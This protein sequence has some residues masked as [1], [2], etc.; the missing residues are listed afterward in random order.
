[1][2]KKGAGTNDLIFSSL[3]LVFIDT[4]TFGKYH[5]VHVCN[6]KEFKVYGGLTTSNMTELLHTG[7][8]PNKRLSPFD[9][10]PLSRS[11]SLSLCLFTLAPSLDSYSFLLLFLS[12]SPSS[13][14]SSVL[15]TLI[16]LTLVL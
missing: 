14:S 15:I 5:K 16:L 4:I 11:L 9:P 12:P 8:L 7:E 2:K 1:M 3:I 10:C 13:S 6:L